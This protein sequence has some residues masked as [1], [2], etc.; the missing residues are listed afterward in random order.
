MGDHLPGKKGEKVGDLKDWKYFTILSVLVA[1]RG[2]K[3]ISISY[4]DSLDTFKTLGKW[5]AGGQLPGRNCG[6][7]NSTKID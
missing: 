4:I 6:D 2:H 5:G 1:C 3:Q 7:L